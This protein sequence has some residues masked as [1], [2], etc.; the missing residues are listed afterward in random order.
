MPKVSISLTD[1]HLRLVTEAV[2]SGDYASS[3]EV[4]REALREWR[5]RRLLDRPSHEGAGQFETTDALGLAA[6]LVG[7][8]GFAA[9]ARRQSTGIAAGSHETD[10]QAFVDAVAVDL[11][12]P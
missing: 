11:D 10:D 7:T 8:P 1:E 2:G 9:E 12:A 5:L 4:I 6:R 3:S